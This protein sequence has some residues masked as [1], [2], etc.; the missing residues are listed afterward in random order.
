MSRKTL[1]VLAVFL[2][3]AGQVS[4]RQ[5]FLVNRMNTGIWAAWSGS[6]I[7]DGG[8]V[9]LEPNGG[10]YTLTVPDNW[11]NGKIWARTGCAFG[12]D[13]NGN[14]LTGD[15]GK[16]R[17]DGESP[18]PPVTLTEWSLESSDGQDFYDVSLIQGY[19]VPVS[20]RPVPGT[21]T[22]NSDNIYECGTAGCVSDLNE[23]C[24]Q[25]L[26]LADSSGKVAGCLSAC[27]KY[28]ADEFCCKGAY[29]SLSRCPPTKYSRLFRSAC[30]YAFSYI[31]DTET[32]SFMCKGADYEVT[33][34]LSENAPKPT[35]APPVPAAENLSLNKS[36]V[37]YSVENDQYTPNLAF[38]GNLSTRWSSEFSDPQWIMV[39][40][41]VYA[42]ITRVVLHWETASAKA[43]QLQ[44]SDT[45]ITWTN[46]YSTD[47]GAGGTASLIVSARGRYVRLF[48]MSRNTPFG[49]SLYEMEVL[50]SW[51]EK[52]LSD[53]T[54]PDE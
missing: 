9:Y 46:I 34:G 11:A 7:P 36:A 42:D 20:I 44:V 19:N 16:L 26:Q 35:D 17:C 48:C 54:Q 49:Y 14:C 47:S 32:R 51:T 39:D 33:F 31:Y 40:L 10:K 6:T 23:V 12:A 27:L 52:E 24:F 4:A 13:G 3:I 38:D 43:F 29:G 5:I 15:C 22:R 53:I 45:G 25:E 8:G 30:P 18:S 28:Q 41:L 50:G 21:Y 1:L 2:A 37:A